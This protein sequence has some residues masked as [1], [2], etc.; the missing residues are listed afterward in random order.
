MLN[1]TIKR[2][3]NIKENK[4]LEEE[5][6]T[7]LDSLMM[8]KDQ[9]WAAKQSIFDFKLF[10]G[11]RYAS[12][13]KGDATHNDLF[14]D[15]KNHS[16]YDNCLRIWSGENIFSKITNDDE[17]DALLTLSWLMFEQ[18]INYGQYAFQ[19]DSHFTI[20]NNHRTRDM[21]MGF[22]KMLFDDIALF[23]DYPHWEK[24]KNGIR[25]YPNFGRGY[26][27]LEN[28]YKKYF[29]EFNNTVKYGDVLSIMQ[30]DNY[31]TSF[32]GFVNNA[33]QNPY[34]NDLKID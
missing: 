2:I 3:T 14:M 20:K 4:S 13:N 27:L 19:Q 34:F 30:V 16:S 29:V 26:Y 9:F 25:L 18:E 12:Y 28:K 32:K 8:N 10:T 7:K 23:I 21:I 22:V 11:E 1:K 33:I 5:R 15:L 6:K 31:L 17:K 24:D